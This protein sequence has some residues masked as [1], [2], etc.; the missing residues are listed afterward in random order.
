MI[1][2]CVGGPSYVGLQADR[3]LGRPL[4]VRVEGICLSMERVLYGL[5]RAGEPAFSERL[6]PHDPADLRALAAERL[7]RCHAVEVWEGPTCIL[8]LRNPSPSDDLS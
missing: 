8:R 4:D 2:L 1:G 7:S 5:D 3:R 6:P